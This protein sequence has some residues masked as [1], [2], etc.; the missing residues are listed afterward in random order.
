[1]NSGD[2]RNSAFQ[3]CGEIALSN[4]AR[5]DAESFRCRLEKYRP[6]CSRGKAGWSTASGPVGLNCFRA[7]AVHGIDHN[8]LV[9]AAMA[10]VRST[11][12]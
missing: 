10:P 12:S 8:S 4:A 5:V 2:D 11:V 3:S 6:F 1:M 9:W 7:N